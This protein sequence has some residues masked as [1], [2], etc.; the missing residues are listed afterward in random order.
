M[1]GLV[2]KPSEGGAGT[3]VHGVKRDRGA[4][5]MCSHAVGFADL[6]E[7]SCCPPSLDCHSLGPTV[8]P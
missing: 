2:S 4:E 1:Q 3:Q 6:C 5:D 8:P 7:D